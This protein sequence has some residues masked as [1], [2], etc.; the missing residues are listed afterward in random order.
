MAVRRRIF[1]RYRTTFLAPRFGSI[2]SWANPFPVGNGFLE[3]PNILILCYLNGSSQCE[4]A[5]PESPSI[6]HDTT[7]KTMARVLCRNG[8]FFL[9]IFFF[10]SSRSEDGAAKCISVPS[11]TGQKKV[12]DFKLFSDEREMDIWHRSASTRKFIY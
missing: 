5:C 8:I 9:I 10:R 7:S 11:A 4:Y 12:H 6:K 3:F 2:S 1:R